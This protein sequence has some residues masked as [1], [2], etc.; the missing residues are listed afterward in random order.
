MTLPST[1]SLSEEA[2]GGLAAGIIGTIIGF[3]FDTIKA[4]KQVGASDR[5]IVE[6]AW[7]IVSTESG[8][9]FALYRGILPPLISLTILNTYTFTTYSY[10]HYM[11]SAKRDWDIRNCAAGATVGIGSS[12]VSS[13]E[14]LIKTQVQ[15][16][17]VREK[18]YRNSL[19]AV[20]QLMQFSG[21]NPVILYTG[22]TVNTIR[23]M[24]FL[25]TYFGVYEG[26]RATLK[27]S[28][29]DADYWAMPAI[30]GGFSGAI[31]WFVSFPLDCV[32]AGVQG[33]NLSNRS[34]QTGA[35]Q[36]FKYLLETKGVR[37]LYSGVTPSIIRAFLVSGSRFSAY[38]GALWLL[39]GGRG[40]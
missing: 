32:R 25:G 1:K 29:H 21:G 38:E 31:S 15:L 17:N 16:D 6:T 33:Q 9:L 30:A 39:R 34:K 5:G 35:V 13:V 19:D 14:N 10:V 20:R 27:H 12:V 22:H 4:R 28:H 37:G 3:P 40:D 26:V 11:Y 8:G 36:V 2:I 23:E 24:V 18:R 7:K